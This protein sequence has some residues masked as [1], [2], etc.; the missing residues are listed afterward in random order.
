M[1]IQQMSMKQP[2][3]IN[4]VEF[5]PL[6]FKIKTINIAKVHLNG[7]CNHYKNGYSRL[8]RKEF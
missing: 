4:D 2:L 8:I 5:I 1:G 3:K 6:D 7:V